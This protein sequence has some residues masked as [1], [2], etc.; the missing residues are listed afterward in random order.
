MFTNVK[1]RF[2]QF[3]DSLPVPAHPD[4]QDA[5]K[6]LVTIMFGFV[7]GGLV[8]LCGLI[9]V[10]TLLGPQ[11][12]EAHTKHVFVPMLMTVAVVMGFALF[13]LLQGHLER[14]CNVVTFA[15]TA[16]ILFSVFMTGGFPTSVASQLLLL[17]PILAYCLLRN[18]VGNWLA[19]IV[20]GVIVV[21]WALTSSG[22]L[23]LP[24]FTSRSNPVINSLITNVFCYMIVVF[25]I[26]WYARQNSLLRRDLAA[27]RNNLVDLANHDELTGLLNVRSFQTRLDGAIKEA[28][29]GTEVFAVISIDLDDFKP[30]NDIH[31]H[32]VGDNLLRIVAKRIASAVRDTDT[33]ARVGGDEFAVILNAD[34]AGRTMER[35]RRAIA[36]R[37]IRIK[38]VDHDIGASLGMAVWTGEIGSREAILEEADKAMYADKSQKHLREAFAA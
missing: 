19:V 34:D 12:L 38:G 24:D 22:F 30:V 8:A 4:G 7:V 32:L 33:A 16:A 15:S 37:P 21:Q 28:V 31:G 18:R 2:G 17:P 27:E 20:P 36:E 10:F 3:I 29:A 13:Q 9:V 5:S 1:T 26:A 25:I 35:I 23:I 6:A 14:A 11:L